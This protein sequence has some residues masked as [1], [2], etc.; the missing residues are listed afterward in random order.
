MIAIDDVRWTYAGATT[1][2]LDGFTLHVRPGET[3]VLCGASGSG[4]S[5]ALRLMNGLVPHFHDGVLTGTV[6]VAGLPVADTPLEQL[7]RRTG[8]VLQHPR[9]QFF[10]D[11]VVPEVAF[12]L[13]NFGEDPAR[14][15]DRVA[16]VRAEHHLAELA[17]RPLGVLSGG[18]QQRV[19]CA[20]A[21][22]HEPALVLFDEPTSNLSPDATRRLVETLRGLREAGTTVVIAEH[23]L[24]LVREIADRVV[25]LRDG[26]VHADWTAAE[27][28]RLDDATL[29][30]EGLRGA[31]ATQARVLPAVRA[32][33][34]SIVR[35]SDAA[36]GP[37]GEEN[38][39]L[40]LE[41]VRCGFRGR[42]VLDVERA[43]LAA[44]TVTAVRGPNG[45]GKT[46]LARVVAGLQ[47]HQG[48]VRLD[49]RPLSRAR[50]QRSTSIVMQDV[51]RQLFTDSVT[52][53]VR[54]DP[55]AD[56]G[57]A[58]RAQ[59]LLRDLGLETLGERHP[60][61]LSGGQQ[62]RL[63]VATARLARRPVVVLDEP[64]SGVDRR[65]LASI[66]R[67]IREIADDGAVVLLVSH[68]EELI[69]LAADH[70]LVLGAPEGAATR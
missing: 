61:A 57:S 66:T 56:A 18:Q 70:E 16:A 30:A 29:E 4:K 51:Q 8:T 67:V 17:G 20:A 25:V 68:D 44:G 32:S 45:A 65:H 3:V 13:E 55:L 23:R 31:R 37:V 48:V 22:A 7:G 21:V 60:L 27:L 62:Q 54:L 59:A 38:P 2:S 52:A 63:V 49:G 39:G 15:R 64:S 36:T 19:A 11:Q 34:A 53:E 12:A 43:H 9:R 46:T 1:P 47:R 69:G 14:I 58:G 40:T 26:R 41:N 6:H 35:R 42:V 24:H 33:G 50:R 5:T 10:T 28:S